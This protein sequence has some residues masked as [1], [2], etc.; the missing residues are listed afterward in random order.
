MNSSLVSIN[1]LVTSNVGEKCPIIFLMNVS[2]QPLRNYL[3]LSNIYCGTS[4]KNKID[5]VEMI[6][7]GCIRK[8]INKDEIRNISINKTKTILNE[9]NISIKSLPG[10]GNAGIK[11]KDMSIHTDNNKKSSIN[12]IV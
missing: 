3:R 2:P 8:K 4:T 1:I 7:Y 10:Y 12:L 11:K 6:I 9:N 5:L